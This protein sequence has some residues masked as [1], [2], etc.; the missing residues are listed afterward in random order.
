M[1][2]VK[3]GICMLPAQD[4]LVWGLISFLPLTSQ[5]W[6][7]LQYHWQ[8]VSF[9]VTVWFAHVHTDVCVVL[10]T[11][12]LSVY[13]SLVCNNSLLLTL[14]LDPALVGL[15]LV[16]TVSLGGLFQ[17]VITLSTEVEGL[18]CT[19]YWPQQL[20]VFCVLVAVLCNLVSSCQYFNSTY[21]VSW[22]KQL[23][24]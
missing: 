13:A 7:L 11:C 9:T 18:V 10:E 17:Y 15:S 21:S 19:M 5:L 2:T 3:D 24:N 4:G 23:H 1:S 14:A 22:V 16:Y 8:A 12:R 6:P 20:N